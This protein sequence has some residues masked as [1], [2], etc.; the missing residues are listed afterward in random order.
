MKSFSAVHFE[1][2]K[3]AEEKA[4]ALL[5]TGRMRAARGKKKLKALSEVMVIEF[6]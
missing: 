5:V 4:V 1:K 3:A 6:M 2:L